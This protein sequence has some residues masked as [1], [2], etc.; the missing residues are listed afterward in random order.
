MGSGLASSQ[1]SHVSVQGQP[2]VVSLLSATTDIV[3]RLGMGHTLVG[4]SHSCDAPPLVLAVE[5]MTQ[6]PIDLALS[7]SK[8]N[9]AMAAK[10][11][12]PLYALQAARIAA[13]DPD[14]I[15]TQSLCRI[16]ASTDEDLHAAIGASEQSHGAQS[17]ASLKRA[18]IVTVQPGTLED[19][20]SDV[21]T[22][23]DALGV[24]E[25]GA[26]LVAHMRERLEAIDPIV[27]EGTAAPLAPG[28]AVSG[29]AAR[30]PPRIAHIGWIAPLMGSGYWVSECAA[31]AGAKLLLSPPGS[32]TVRIALSDLAEADAIVI[33][34]CGFDLD[35]IALDFKEAPELLHSA[36]W[37]ALPAVKA[38]RVYCADGNR[39]FNRSST[40]VVTTAEVLAEIAHGPELVGLWGHHGK[41]WV[42][43]S[44]LERFASRPGHAHA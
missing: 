34:P 26:R 16:C 13:L 27:R 11:G 4:R 12:T 10:A 5:P 24:P 20:L 38:G 33:A 25:R 2:R 17:V 36:G 32:A 1:P 15:I 22:I 19:V 14:V 3:M 29:A 35:R 40:D 37:R 28:A 18:K 42:R 30:R 44:E 9:D 23:A 43:L 31:A 6:A 39:L 21:R 41:E 8:I 7:S